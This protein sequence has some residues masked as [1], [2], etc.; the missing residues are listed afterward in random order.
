MAPPGSE[1][2][3]GAPVPDDVAVGLDLLSL[4]IGANIPQDVLKQLGASEPEISSAFQERTG[5]VDDDR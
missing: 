2:A 3:K 5:M 1:A 4:S